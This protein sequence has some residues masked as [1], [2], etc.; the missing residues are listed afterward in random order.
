MKKKLSLIVVTAVIV[1]VTICNI[2]ASQKTGNLSDLALVNIE[3]LAGDESGE[4]YFVV[5]R[6]KEVSTEYTECHIIKTYEA[7]T[8]CPPG[9]RRDCYSGTVIEKEVFPDPDC[10][11]A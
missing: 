10:D 9:G 4:G 8:T 2:N 3:A 7:I 5:T 11:C 6:R 1:V